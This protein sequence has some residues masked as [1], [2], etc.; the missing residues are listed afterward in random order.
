MTQQANSHPIGPD[1]PRVRALRDK[2]IAELDDRIGDTLSRLPEEYF[3]QIPPDEHLQHFKALVAIKVCEIDQEIMI[4]HKNGN[5]VTVISHQNHPGLLARLIRGLPRE[6][7]LVG[8]KIFTSLDKD[9]IVDV[10][11]FQD[12]FEK[13][14]AVSDSKELCGLVAKVQQLTGASA[15][16]VATFVERYDS[17]NVILNSPEEVAHQYVA[18]RETAH[19]NDIKVLCEKASDST[20]Q[21][22]V[23]AASSTTRDV[24]ERSA[25]FFGRQEIDIHRAVCENVIVRDTI[26]VA[27]LTFNVEMGGGFNTQAFAGSME[28]FLSVDEEVILGLG[29]LATRPTPTWISELGFAELFC[30][31]GKLTQHQINFCESV[32]LSHERVLRTMR[33]HFDLSA[34]A[35]RGLYSRFNADMYRGDSTAGM[36]DVPLQQITDP[37]ERRTIKTLFRLAGEIQRANFRTARRRGIAFRLPGES[38]ENLSRGESPHAVFFVYGAGFEGFHVRFR[39]V[40]RGGM[41]LVPTRNGEHFVFESSRTFDEAWRLATA[42]QLKNKDIAEG[43]AKAVVVVKPGV[44]PGRAG[45]DFVEGLLDLITDVRGASALDQENEGEEFL[46]LGPDENVTN[47][48]INWIVDRSSDRGYRFPETIMSSKPTTG[49]NHKEFGVTSEGVL[50]FL[51]HAL[52]EHGIDPKKEPFSVKLTGGPDG[53]VGGNAIKILARDYRDTSRIVGIADGTGSASDPQGLEKDEL[54]RLFREGLGIAEFDPK[55][56]S[57][58]GEVTGLRTESEITRRNELH[59]TIKSDVFLPAGGRPSTIN[60]NNWQRFLDDQGVPSS[61]IVVEG[62]NLFITDQARK[63]LSAK[64]VSIIKDSSANKCGVICSSMEIMAGMLMS[65]EQFVAS[66]ADYVADVLKVLASLAEIEAISLFNDGLRRPDLTLPEI[67]VQISKQIIRVGDVV[68]KTCDDWSAEDQELA[69]EYVGTFLPA[70]L[71]K[72]LGGG[73][74][75][76]IPESYRRQLLSA[77]LA[78]R[79]VYREGCFSIQTMRDDS[80][81]ALARKTLAYEANVREMVS[82]VEG[83]DLA[84]KSGIADILRHAGT[85]AQRDLKW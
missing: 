55:K 13:K 22:T 7:P 56:L 19:E 18:L 41:R 61:P 74:V 4:R 26:D 39:E 8:A 38:F 5:R 21:V 31:L 50:V 37:T 85:R 78:S 51:K 75:E 23:S 9:F 40:A 25:E 14:L 46:Y 84:G 35:L 28:H 71:E 10:F 64:G 33:K 29:D 82:Q 27:L 16:E 62:A 45:R 6:K 80:I 65:E 42:Q 81:A 12:A 49:I 34:E 30:C 2:I 83:S 79:I 58:D 54:L 36:P 32:N 11:E 52:L 3:Q 60:E 68:E 59:N 44:S 43:G 57:A 48:L 66:K 70:T 77:L 69:N 20:C 76:K 17:R 47:E 1:S 24:F 63:E 53:D 67:S 15:E 72:V 73:V